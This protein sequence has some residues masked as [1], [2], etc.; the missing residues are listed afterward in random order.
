MNPVV[1]LLIP[2]VIVSV[3]CTVLFVRGRKPTSL[4]S[5]IEDFQREMRALAPRSEDPGPRS[6]PWLRLARRR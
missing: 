2:V 5:G 1:F 3:G 4:R 6:R